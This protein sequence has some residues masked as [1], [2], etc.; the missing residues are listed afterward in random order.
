MSAPPLLAYPAPA[1]ERRQIVAATTP[2]IGVVTCFANSLQNQKFRELSVGSRGRKRVSNGCNFRQK[3]SCKSFVF[4]IRNCKKSIVGHPLAPWALL[5]HTF[6]VSRNTGNSIGIGH[7][8]SRRLALKGRSMVS[9]RFSLSIP[10]ACMTIR[11]GPGVSFAVFK[12]VAIF[13]NA[14]PLVYQEYSKL[15]PA[16]GGMTR[17]ALQRRV[18]TQASNLGRNRSQH[19]NHCNTKA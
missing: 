19:T 4:N 1:A 7:C 9:S 15:I 8:I 2:K 13:L 18:L 11:S 6:G 16:V 10:D 3:R 5:L 12:V 17:F 14:R